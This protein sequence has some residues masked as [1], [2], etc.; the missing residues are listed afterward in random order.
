M[1]IGDVSRILLDDIDWNQ[2]TIRVTNRKRATPFLLPLPH[3]VG[4]AIVDYLLY[5]RPQSDSRN[6]FLNHSRHFLGCPATFMSLKDE[7]KRLWE[8]TGLPNQYSGTHIFRR[9]TATALKCQGMSLKTIS[10][11]LGHTSIESTALYAQ[12]DIVSLRKVA[13]PWPLK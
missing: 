10:D 2:G 3:R 11:L 8:K 9:S 4:E 7:I 12:V 1:R 6:L 5:G 13:Q